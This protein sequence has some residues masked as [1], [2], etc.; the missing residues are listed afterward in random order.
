MA[1]GGARAHVGVAM[2]KGDELEDVV[3]M[4]ADIGMLYD[5]DEDQLDFFLQHSLQKNC[6][7]KKATDRLD[8]GS[9]PPPFSHIRQSRRPAATS[10]NFPLTSESFTRFNAS[11]LLILI[12][13]RK[14]VRPRNG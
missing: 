6:R 12:A 8:G 5:E 1:G 3:M 11:P 9:A 14:L 7:I 4:Q 2:T 13:A 10:S